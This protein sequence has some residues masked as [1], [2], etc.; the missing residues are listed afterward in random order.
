MKKLLLA[1]AILGMVVQGRATQLSGTYTIDA[2]GTA[3]ATTFKDIVSAITYLTSAGTRPDGGPSNSAPFGVSGPVVFD[4]ATGSG[5]YTG[6]VVLP[7][8][9]GASLTNTVTINGNG[10]TIQ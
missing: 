4:V 1:F 5:P 6:Q 7:N 9:T 10:N 2:S 3:T 8:V